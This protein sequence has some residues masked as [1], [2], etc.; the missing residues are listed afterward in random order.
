M[1]AE[2]CALSSVKATIDP[3]LHL[4]RRTTWRPL[5]KDEFP[6]VFA[7][8]TVVTFPQSRPSSCGTGFFSWRTVGRYSRKMNQKKPRN[9]VES[10]DQTFLPVG[11]GAR[12]AFRKRLQCSIPHVEGRRDRAF[13]L[14]AS[15]KQLAVGPAIG[16]PVDQRR[17]S[18]KAKYSAALVPNSTMAL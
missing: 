3:V 9:I 1:L 4:V 2:K 6:F 16:Q 10:R 7:K 11:P 18:V 5:H 13:F 15:E 8:A 12:I 14:V 17:A